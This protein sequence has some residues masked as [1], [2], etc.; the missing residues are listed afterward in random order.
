MNYLMKMGYRDPNLIDCEV[1]LMSEG[2][3]CVYWAT[4]S[5]ISRFRRINL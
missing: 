1:I 3:L 2:E 5:T 4:L